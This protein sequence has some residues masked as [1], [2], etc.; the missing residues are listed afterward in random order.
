MPGVHH[1]ADAGPGEGLRRLLK[2]LLSPPDFLD[3]ELNQ[4]EGDQAVPAHRGDLGDLQAGKKELSRVIEG[5]VLENDL[6]KLGQG[7]SFL[8]KAPSWQAAER[9]QTPHSTQSSDSMTTFFSL[10][11]IAPTGQKGMH[12]AQVWHFS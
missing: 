12:R 9:A 2:G 8:I 11:R 3:Q 5:L 6:E 7:R 10:T 4:V 1:P